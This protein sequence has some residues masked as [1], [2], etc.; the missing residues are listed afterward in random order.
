MSSIQPVYGI[1]LGA[2]LLSEIPST[3][4][5]LGGIFIIS[6]VVIESIISARRA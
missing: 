6:A 2:I 5:L 3:K 1:A 4:T